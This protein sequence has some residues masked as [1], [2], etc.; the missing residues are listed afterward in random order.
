M[1]IHEAVKEAMKANG[2]II[3]AE[4]EEGEHMFPTL[5]KPI[6]PRATCIFIT[7]NLPEYPEEK[8]GRCKYWNP[9]ADDLV[10]DDWQVVTK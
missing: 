8:S 4:I 10:A 7:E 9:T 6:K 3:R 5:I 2:Y 1:H